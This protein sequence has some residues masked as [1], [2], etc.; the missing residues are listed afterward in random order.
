MTEKNKQKIRDGVKNFLNGKNIPSKR[1]LRRYSYLEKIAG[2]S[3]PTECE[4][5]KRKTSLCYDHN[6]KDMKFRGWICNDCNLALGFAKDNIDIL[7]AMIKY[8][9]ENKNQ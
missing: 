2:R 7:K 1:T 4:I 5:C 3:K 8:L 9:D 6:H